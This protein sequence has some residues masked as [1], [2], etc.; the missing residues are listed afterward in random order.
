MGLIV[1]VKI[2]KYTIG[3]Y[4]VYGAYPI[5]VSKIR[6]TLMAHTLATKTIGNEDLTSSFFSQ[7]KG[8]CHIGAVPMHSDT[9]GR[10]HAHENKNRL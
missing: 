2:K 7:C 9:W 4:I 6:V 10:F 8:F 5:I 1:N 3:L